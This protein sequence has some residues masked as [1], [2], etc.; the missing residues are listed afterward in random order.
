M[1]N[2][3]T[4]PRGLNAPRPIGTPVGAHPNVRTVSTGL[5]ITRR[6]NAPAAGAWKSS[7]MSAHSLP[8]K[9][10]V[11][12]GDLLSP[13][14]TRRSPISGACNEWR[15]KPPR[16]AFGNER[17]PLSFEGESGVHHRDTEGTEEEGL[18]RLTG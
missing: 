1:E 10:F 9:G 18:S 16:A 4:R 5:G 8:T 11:T 3:D 2:E 6:A 14:S 12:R 7:M 17:G 15:L 13:S